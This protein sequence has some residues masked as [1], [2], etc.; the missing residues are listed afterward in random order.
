MTGPVQI[1]RF[2]SWVRPA[3]GS[4]VTAQSGGRA[5]AGTS[6]TLTESGA[7]GGTRRTEIRPVSFLL[8]GPADVTGLQPGAIVRRYPAPGTLNHE[9]DR[10]PY[11]ELADPAL[12]W[13][14]TPAPTPRPADAG[15]H[16]WLVLV[17][18]LE[19][20][21]LTL[22]GG[23][24]TIA[25]TAQQDPQTLG[26]PPS[27]YRFAHVQ[28]DTAGHRVARVLSGRPLQPG[29]D[30]LAVVVPAYDTSGA[31]SW[32]GVQPVTVPV[33]DAWRFRTAVPA[34]SFENLAALLHP[35][36]VPATAGRAPLRYPRLAGVPELSVLG[37]LVARPADG[38]VTED[39]LPEIVRT[40]LRELLGLSSHDDKGRPIVTLPRYGEAWP[41]TAFGQSQLDGDLNLDP[42]HRGVAGLGLE[43][44]I[45]AQG[46]LVAD[47]LA[48]LGALREA[49]QRVR[50]LVLGLAA[51]RSL[52]QRR[53]PA[54][55]AA[56]LWLLG[57]S[58]NRLITRNGAVGEL[59]TADD[60]TIAQGTF[61]AAARRV[62]R[63]GPAR[64]ALAAAAPAPA[65]LVSSANRPPPP[66]PASVDGVP[67]DDAGLRAFDTAR[68][69]VIRSGH[70][71]TPAMLAAAD[72]LAAGATTAVRPAATQIAATMRQ[73]AQAGRAVPWGQALATLASGDATVVAEARNPST[74]LGALNRGMS[75]LRDRVGNAEDAGL[76]REVLG[77]QDNPPR[78][79]DGVELTEM[80]AALSPLEPADPAVRPVAVNA[81]AAG[82]S[83]AFDPST[84]DAPAAARVL[85]TIAGGIDPAQ[86][87]APPEPCAGLGRP[88]WADL[89]EASGEWLLPGV[90]QLP[91]NCVIV[92]QSNPIF[93]DAYLTG[94]NTQLL[95]ELRW[96]NIPIATG[97][98]PIRRFW[99]RA[100]TST[101]ERADDIIGVASWTSA[102]AL[103][104]PAHFAPGA[105]GRELVIAVHGELLV[106]YPTTLVYL[107]PAV[108]PGAT[109]ANFDA[110]PADT[111][112][113]VLPG[114]HGRIGADVVFFGFPTIDDT[115]LARHWLIFEEPP[116]GYRFDNGPVPAGVSTGHQWA[117][118]ALAQ[119][120]RVLIAGDSFVSGG[121]P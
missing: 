59:A 78:A 44:G 103:G 52:W 91:D 13:R 71:N 72:E 18:G 38:R 33:Y 39:P 64:T 81:L 34:G 79:G 19:D 111:A 41:I 26:D 23:Q 88:A 22:T 75:G 76:S 48:N 9:S 60:R 5:Q 17:V 117:A 101:G 46:D 8:A 63:A 98:T 110:D 27:A 80:L 56:R 47:V 69:Q 106:R 1:L 7:D 42:R 14:Y 105:T 95:G 113:R 114:F 99:D 40:D 4:L 108:P 15:L 92:L 25:V 31:R 120:V 100:D 2:L 84:A 70:V 85:A 36:G 62:V 116:S 20:S 67:M 49:R 53:V 32:T 68:A 66:P 45:R 57:P 3:I 89:A 28:E 104:D 43:V 54:D 50:H 30:Y 109:A 12:P 21:E 119:P 86:P 35:G 87:L 77:P 29:T 121:R 24:V 107:Q 83:A 37:A 16:P 74:L 112:A 61:S 97:C 94:L 90:G 58:L 51:S 11:I 93:I 55:P 10:C 102:S 82:V 65:A 96:R 118:A 115:A 73:A 6:I